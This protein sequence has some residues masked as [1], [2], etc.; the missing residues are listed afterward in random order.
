METRIPDNQV[1]RIELLIDS[2]LA[3]QLDVFAMAL[4]VLKNGREMPDID[5][6]RTGLTAL[7][8]VFKGRGSAGI[9]TNWTARFYP[10]PNGKSGTL[11]LDD[12]AIKQQ[13]AVCRDRKGAYY[14]GI[15]SHFLTPD[16]IEGLLFGIVSTLDGYRF[17][18]RDGKESRSCLL[19]RDLSGAIWAPLSTVD[20][21]LPESVAA[22]RAKK[23]QLAAFQQPAE[24][25]AEK[26]R[27]E[28]IPAGQAG[29]TNRLV[30]PHGAGEEPAPAVQTRPLP[31][32]PE[33]GVKILLLIRQSDGVIFPVIDRF[34]I[35]RERQNNL[36]LDDRD[37]SR[38]HA[39][40]EPLPGGWQIT[41]LNSTNGI[42]L[43][44]ARIKGAA[45][46]KAGDLLEL[47]KTKFRLDITVR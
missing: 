34:T 28:I 6:L 25:N 10:S 42:Y 40:I 47:G 12:Y 29:K 44:G 35:G 1:H 17:E 39:T 38:K 21:S 9:R 24:P 20:E 33:G 4:A 18:V 16:T 30:L 19:G 36:C 26:A 3:H 15:W 41:D 32:Q 31:V 45:R 5:S 46:I 8:D 14:G 27:T 2:D 43:N 13:I 37:V 23:S 7:V 22:S 11:N